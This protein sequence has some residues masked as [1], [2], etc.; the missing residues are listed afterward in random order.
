MEHRGLEEYLKNDGGTSRV[1][2]VRLGFFPSHRSPNLF[3]SQLTDIAQGLFHMHD[4]DII[5]GNVKIVRLSLPPNTPRYTHP[6]T[7]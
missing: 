2:L 6:V 5:H 3:L 1:R 4:L 7:E